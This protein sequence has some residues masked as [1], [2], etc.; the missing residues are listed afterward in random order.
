M[1]QLNVV[2]SYNDKKTSVP[3]ENI[4]ST[5]VVEKRY[6]SRKKDEC[7]VMLIQ[8]KAGEQVFVD[9]IGCGCE[10]GGP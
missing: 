8:C 9:D 2:C 10:P 6:L 4:S 5:P 1:P 3:S 7:A